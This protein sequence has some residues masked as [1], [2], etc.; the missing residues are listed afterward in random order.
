[1]SLNYVKCEAYTTVY[2]LLL[3]RC[4]E[5]HP[6][7]NW[8]LSISMDAIETGLYVYKVTYI[9]SFVV[10]YMYRYIVTYI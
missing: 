2:E 5:P 1:M 10:T 4:P 3:Q 7:K 6:A 9:Y 8:L